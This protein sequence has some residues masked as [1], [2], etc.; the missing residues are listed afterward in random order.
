MSAQLSIAYDPSYVGAQ[1]WERHL[2]VIRTVVEHLGRK[3]VAYVLDVSGS[4][5]SD[6]MSER[7][8]KRWAGEWTHK[9]FAM[10]EGKRDDVSRGLSRQLAESS[11]G[12]CSW[13]VDEPSAMTPEEEAMALRR[14][15]AALGESGRAAL[16]RVKR[17]KK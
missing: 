6:A 14:E 11:L 2:S 7:D 4:Q 12:A 8:R 1:S 10:L 5:L 16:E 15:L 9:L 3:E 17:R 13:L